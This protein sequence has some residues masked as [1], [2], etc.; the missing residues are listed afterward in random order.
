MA[1]NSNLLTKAIPKSLYKLRCA[2]IG[3]LQKAE[4]SY[5]SRNSKGF[6]RFTPGTGD[7]KDQ[8]HVLLYYSYLIIKSFLIV[9]D[10]KQIFI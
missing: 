6:R 1:E 7:P 8:I 2:Q 5:H 9:L 10:K 4:D 3:S